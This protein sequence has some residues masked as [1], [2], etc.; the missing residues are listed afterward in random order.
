LFTERLEKKAT[1]AA[2]AS[3]VAPD[4]LPLPGL[5]SSPRVTLAVESVW[6]SNA[7]R[8]L[9]WTKGARTTPAVLLDGC[10][11]KRSWAGAAG[12]TSKVAEVALPRSWVVAMRV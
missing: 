10:T 12:E 7:S 1:P 8:S 9:T 3:V 5:A 4:S 2:A 6:L 11:P